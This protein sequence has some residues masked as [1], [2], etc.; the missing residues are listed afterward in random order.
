MNAL[1]FAFFCLLI[2]ATESK[3]YLKCQLHDELIIRGLDGYH[4]IGIGHWLCLVLFSSQFDTAHYEFTDGHPYYGLFYLSGLLWC[5]NGRHPTKNGCNI[6]CEKFLDDNI[7]DDIECVKKVS[8]SKK[9]MF[10]WKT[11][12]EYCIHP[13]P[14]ILY[15]EC[16]RH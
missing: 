4:G 1:D 14:S 3:K 6:D 13:M 12:E 8:A 9:G 7:A 10:V 5:D 11:F 15:W 16:N 2:V